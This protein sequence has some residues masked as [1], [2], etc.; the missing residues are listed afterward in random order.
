MY[1]DEIKVT[2][3][4]E[5]G[6]KSYEDSSN[7]Q[8]TFYGVSSNLNAFKAKITEL[9]SATD[10]IALA[11]GTVAYTMDDGASYMYYRPTDTWYS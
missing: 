1:F 2:I 11:T 3:E 5:T 10:S 8:I 6:F 7:N 4:N 9:I